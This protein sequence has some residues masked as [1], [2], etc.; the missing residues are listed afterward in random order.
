MLHL[1]ILKALG[2]LRGPELTGVLAIEGVCGDRTGDLG[3]DLLG[4]V[5]PGGVKLL[6]P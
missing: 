5:R 3:E 2:L 1:N 6:A 4:G